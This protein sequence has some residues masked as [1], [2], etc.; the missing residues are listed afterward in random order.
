MH[1]EYCRLFALRNNFLSA[2]SN[3]DGFLRREL[4]ERDSKSAVV[5]YIVYCATV[6]D[7]ESRG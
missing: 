1:Y 5:N 7:V 6:C 2:G 4:A 3:S